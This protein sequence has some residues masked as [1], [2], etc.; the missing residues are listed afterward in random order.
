M[1]VPMHLLPTRT[2]CKNNDKHHVDIN[3]IKNYLKVDSFIFKRE[4]IIKTKLHSAY[5]ILD[6]ECVFE[7]KYLNI[8]YV[9][10]TPNIAW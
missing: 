4:A 9:Y 8:V 10:P 1:T 5:S 6:D 7:K 3:N 2:A